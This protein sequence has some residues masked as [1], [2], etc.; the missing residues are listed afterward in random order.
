MFNLSQRHRRVS[1]GLSVALKAL[2]EETRERED[3]M[4]RAVEERFR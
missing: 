4:R 3:H 1:G 2:S